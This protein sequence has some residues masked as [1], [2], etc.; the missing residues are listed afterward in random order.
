ML[1]RGTS[2]GADL[3]PQTSTRFISTQMSW[4]NP[5]QWSRVPAFEEVLG[6]PHEV[7]ART[8]AD[9][10]WRTRAREQAMSLSGQKDFLDGDI[11][12]Y[13]DR[14]SV[15]ET[16]VHSRLR[17]IP[18]S[19]LAADR[20]AHPFDV[21]MD[22]ALEDDLQTRFRTVSPGTDEELRA[23]VTDRR[24]VLGAHDGGAHV[25]MLCDS[26]YPSYTLRYWVR[27][28]QAM[29]AAEAAYRMS[30][31]PAQ[32]FGLTE[33]GTIEVGKAADLIAYDPERITELPAER[34]W[35]FPAGADRL[36]AR[37]DGLE[38]VW[39]AGTAIRRHAEIVDGAMPG[40]LVS[41]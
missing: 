26:C 37:N 25:D 28:Q 23:L 21:M 19:R 36:I 15:E 31:Q 2:T 11:A 22:L 38:H 14:T 41:R 35:D 8:Y 13:F 30:G 34:V 9:P 39:V 16:K 7:M 1:D 40:R 3:W 20:G 6:R 18:L 27:E 32:L 5:Y 4:L 17:G 12:G 24:T 10:E 29:D 33:R